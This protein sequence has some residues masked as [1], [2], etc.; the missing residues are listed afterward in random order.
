[1]ANSNYGI[2]IVIIVILLLL[3]GFGI[4]LLL[5]PKSPTGTPPVT[6]KCNFTKYFESE[7]LESYPIEAQCGD[8]LVTCINTLTPLE[9]PLDTEDSIYTKPKT[10]LYS[11]VIVFAKETV[12]DTGVCVTPSLKL[13]QPVKA[14]YADFLESMWWDPVN[15]KPVKRSK[16]YN[17]DGLVREYDDQ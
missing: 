13:K 15:D 2:I 4:W 8:K 5:R 3:L 16:F 1:M 6:G 17:F 11:D 12:T 10:S 7:W 9:H 14:S